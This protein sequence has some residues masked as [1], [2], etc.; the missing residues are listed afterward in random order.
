MRQ[1]VLE[2]VFTLGEQ[3]CLIEQLGA[4]EVGEAAVEHLL[5]RSGNG[6]QEG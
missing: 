2:G 6:L 3:P 4:L 1:G 5:W